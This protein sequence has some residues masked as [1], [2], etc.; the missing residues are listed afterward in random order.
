M[1]KPSTFADHEIGCRLSL[2][3]FNKLEGMCDIIFC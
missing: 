3:N 2:D 1:D